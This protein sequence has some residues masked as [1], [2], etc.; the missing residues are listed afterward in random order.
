MLHQHLVPFSAGDC[1]MYDMHSPAAAHTHLNP[2][3]WMHANDT[4]L[5]RV[6][7]WVRVLVK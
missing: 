7:T 4:L 1:A 3:G 6:V 2:P 5:S